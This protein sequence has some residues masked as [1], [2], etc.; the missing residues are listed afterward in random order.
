MCHFIVQYKEAIKA[1]T[2]DQENGLWR[3]EL[4]RHEWEIVDQLCRAL[5]VGH[6]IVHDVVLLTHV[7]LSRS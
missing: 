6:H 1:F 7:G 2:S 4:S 3:Y 5:K